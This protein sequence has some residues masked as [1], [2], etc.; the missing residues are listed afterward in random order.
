MAEERRNGEETFKYEVVK[1]LMEHAKMPRME[2]W[3]EWG[4]GKWG[5]RCKI[6]RVP[7]QQLE[8]QSG[9]SLA[10]KSLTLHLQWWLAIGWTCLF[11]LVLEAT[12]LGKQHRMAGC[13]S[14]P[15]TLSFGDWKSVL[16]FLCLCRTASS[17]WASLRIHLLAHK[18]HLLCCKEGK[19][20]FVTFVDIFGD[21]PNLDDCMSVILFTADMDVDCNGAESSLNLRVIKVKNTHLTQ[22]LSAQLPG[23]CSP[24]CSSDPCRDSIL[25]VLKG[26]GRTDRLRFRVSFLVINDLLSRGWRD[27]DVGP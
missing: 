27:N 14:V 8:S 20:V 10:W 19:K 9:R 13:I 1:S 24:C 7:L 11:W 5:L 12:L 15:S 6:W 22:L 23:A 26:S 25:F 18:W 21:W 4:K 17:L 3:E 2:W 16:W